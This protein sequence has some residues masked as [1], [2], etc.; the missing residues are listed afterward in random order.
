MNTN[1]SK[2]TGVNYIEITQAQVGQRL[3]NLLFKTLKH[4]PKTWVYRI[5]RKGE[6]RVN[7]KRTRPDYKVQ[8]GDRVRIPPLFVDRQYEAEVFIPPGLLTDIENSVLFENPHIMVIDK[9]AGL[10]VHSGSGV[11]FGVI[12]IMRCI[13]PDC[14]IEL[15]HRLDRDTSGCLL[16]AK[17]RQSLLAMQKCIQNNSIVKV[18]LAV[19]RGLWLESKREISHALI[20]KTMP[21]GE[22]RVYAD[23]QGQ[24]ALT[25]ILDIKTG[26]AY[27][28]LTIRLVTGR[29]H[30]IRAHCQIEGHEIA[31]DRKYGD[32]RFNRMMKGRG[33]EG[34]ML[35]ATRL[36]L[37]DSEFCQ[38]M[39]ID[40]K[41]PPG[42]K[43][44]IGS[45]A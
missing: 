2:K 41:L 30:Q 9:P 11:S 1:T 5:I 4:V 20:R 8:A 33:V 36:E 7:K 24:K 21:N 16:L 12:D 29:T 19:V 25:R 39:T 3:D 13:R 27:S 38:A 26:D 35:H 44:L 17:H 40:A 14:E 32:T 42:F 28:L 43:G 18:Y 23:P 31:G 10:A 45:D 15:V 6:V 22:R 37:P 34:L